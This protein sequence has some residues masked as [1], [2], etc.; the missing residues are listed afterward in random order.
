MSAPRDRSRRVSTRLYLIVGLLLI[1]LPPAGYFGAN[2]YVTKKK[3]AEECFRRPLRE[4]EFPKRKRMISRKVR[5]VALSTDGKHALSGGGWYET[6]DAHAELLLREAESGRLIREFAFPWR[7]RLCGRGIR[8][9][10]FSADGRCALSSGWWRDAAGDHAELLLWDIESGRLVGEF[11][12]PEREGISGR[13][14]R[15]VALSP[16]GN[17]ELGGGW[18]LDTAGT[19][20]AELL[21]WEAES[22]RLIREFALPEREGVSERHLLSVALSPDGKRALA[23]GRWL[24]AANAHA[25]LLLWEVES[26][27]LIREFAFPEREGGGWRMVSVAAL[28]ADG[29]RALAGG[30]WWKKGTAEERRAGLLLWE[31]ESG[32]LVR[33]FVLPERE[34]MSGRNFHSVAF[35]ADGK[36]T[37]SG[38]SWSDARGKD[39]IELLLWEVESGRLVREFALPEREGMSRRCLFS[40]TLSRDGRRAL[41]GGW[42]EGAEGE[43]HAELLLWELPDEIGYRL[44][45]TRDAEDAE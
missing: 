1:V 19:A 7:E 31:I 29:R 45:G 16:D 10:A 13:V 36:R 34:G 22:G 41:T 11:A 28:S 44:L 20:H 5:Y 43:D 2:W 30:E 42:W 27:R 14:V 35:S 26:G 8:S 18:W 37:L 9:V 38:G 4:F 33:K 40:V 32:Q 3:W 39:H 21:L 15:S 23:G 6:L 24:D 17:S 12:L 25:E